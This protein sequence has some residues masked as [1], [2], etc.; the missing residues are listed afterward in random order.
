MEC[1]NVF[2]KDHYH[3]SCECRKSRHKQCNLNCKVRKKY[4][5]FHNNSD[6]G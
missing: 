5:A 4:A 3:V 2:G 6:K 1:K